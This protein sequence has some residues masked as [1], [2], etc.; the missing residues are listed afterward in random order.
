MTHGREGKCIQGVWQGNLK[1]RD[2]FE[3]PGLDGRKILKL[4]F[5]QREKDAKMWTELIWLGTGKSGGLL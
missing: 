3:D 2:H 4:E 5:K 1:E